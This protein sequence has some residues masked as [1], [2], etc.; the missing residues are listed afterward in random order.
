MISVDLS[1]LLILV[2]VF[3]LVLALKRL[4]FEPLAGAIEA[5]RGRIEGADRLWDETRQALEGIQ[6]FCRQAIQKARQEGYER[7]D[8]IRAEART[9]AEKALDAEKRR[10]REEIAQAREELR[11]QGEEAVGALEVEAHRLAGE[12]ATRILG[13]RVA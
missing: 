11:R 6:T 2:L 10:A 8:R 7:L 1:A 4:F 9:E 13:R 3:S 12:L 5:R